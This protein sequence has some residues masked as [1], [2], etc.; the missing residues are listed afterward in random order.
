MSNKGNLTIS[1]YY[2]NAEL[3]FVFCGQCFD[4]N[5]EHSTPIISSII[6][7][8]VIDVIIN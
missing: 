1:Y 3:L 2:I 5:I 8:K 7:T 4:N 6:S